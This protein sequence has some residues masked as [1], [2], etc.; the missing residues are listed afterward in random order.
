MIFTSGWYFLVQFPPSRFNG[1]GYWI[2]HFPSIKHKPTKLNNIKWKIF[3]YS[4][5]DRLFFQTLILDSQLNGWYIR[6]ILRG[7]S[8]R[9][10]GLILF[11]WHCW[12]LSCFIADCQMRN[13]NVRAVNPKRRK[14]S[15]SSC[16]WVLTVCL[17]RCLAINFCM[18]LCLP[19]CNQSKHACYLINPHRV[20]KNCMVSKFLFCETPSIWL[21]RIFY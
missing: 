13:V 9:I 5:R 17:S 12:L 6:S 1:M 21:G 20:M 19:R 11:C 8:R 3:K 4:D 15:S 7:V 14:P 18:S 10:F 16:L 2:V